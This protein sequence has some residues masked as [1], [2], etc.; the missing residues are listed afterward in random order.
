[1]MDGMRMPALRVP[2]FLALTG[3][4]CVAGA[5][6]DDWPDT[7]PAVDTAGV[8]EGELAF[9]SAMPARRVLRTRNYL[10]ITPDS[11]ASGWVALAQ[12][13]SDLDPVPAAEVVYRYHGM[14][15]L[16]IVSSTDMDA[17]VVQGNSVQLTGIR[18]GGEVCI[19]AE[20]Q[21]LKPGGSGGF[22]LQSGPFHRR[23]LDGYYPLQLDYRVEW[24]AGRLQLES[25]TPG[26]QEG[27]AVSSGPDFVQVDALFEGMLTIELQFA[28]GE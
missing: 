26:G 10:T 28:A 15:G 9:L 22:R 17:A 3:W 19:A 21:V 6:E 25:I 14:R 13:Q 11:L 8:N 12:C 20:V 16:R 27:F 7:D 23:F 1:M 18:P 24:P 5:A 4:L 2:V